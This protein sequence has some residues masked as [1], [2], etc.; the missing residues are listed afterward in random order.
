MAQTWQHTF[1]RS[2][3][4]K[5]ERL[6]LKRTRKNRCVFGF[7]FNHHVCVC[8]REWTKKVVSKTA[9][10]SSTHPIPAP[11]PETAVLTPCSAVISFSCHTEKKKDAT[12]EQIKHDSAQKRMKGT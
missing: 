1:T 7:H 2:E 3:Y 12:A 5:K 9:V 8:A 4:N 11:F 6:S 10:N